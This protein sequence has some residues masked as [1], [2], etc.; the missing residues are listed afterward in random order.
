MELASFGLDFRTRHDF[1]DIV[2]RALDAFPVGLA[3][4][5]EHFDFFKG[6]VVAVSNSD[7][8]LNKR[9]TYIWKSER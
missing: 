4:Q 8:R 3:P 6:A 5:R 7:Q 2:N 1:A 9:V